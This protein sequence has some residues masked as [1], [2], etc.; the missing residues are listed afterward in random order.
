MKI[1][2]SG[3]GTSSEILLLIFVENFIPSATL[4][5]L[6]A[7]LGFCDEENRQS[8][9]LLRV[10]HQGQHGFDIAVRGVY[11]N[12]LAKDSAGAGAESALQRGRSLNWTGGG[13]CTEPKAE[14]ALE[15]GGICTEPGAESTLDRGR[16]LH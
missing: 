2:K 10:N 14:P 11:S 6:G 1:P 12:R 7:V 16:S 9:V 5:T 8:S 3:P 15:R 13:V 4:R